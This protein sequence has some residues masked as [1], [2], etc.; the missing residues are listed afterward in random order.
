MSGI[1]SKKD[2]SFNKDEYFNFLKSIGY[3]VNEKE[4]FK[5][6]NI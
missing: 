5:I 4:D 2:T 3:I 6:R 1:L